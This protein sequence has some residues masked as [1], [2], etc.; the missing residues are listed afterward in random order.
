MRNYINANY[1]V[2]DD[3]LQKYRALA[4][5]KPMKNMSGNYTCSVSTYSSDDKKTTHLQMIV[6]ESELKLI[7]KL[8]EENDV[9]SIECYAKN[10]YPEPEL[11]IT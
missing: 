5:T 11:Q 4:I 7:T 3:E 2:S 1:T 6:P 10:I 9:L 8:D